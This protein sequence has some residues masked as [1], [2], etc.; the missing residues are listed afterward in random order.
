MEKTIKANFGGGNTAWEERKLGSYA[1]RLIL[2]Q[3]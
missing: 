2:V 1:K 3:I